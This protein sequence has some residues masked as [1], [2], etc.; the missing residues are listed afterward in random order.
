M[1]LTPEQIAAI[2]ARIEP[3]Y[4]SVQSALDQ[5]EA[6]RAAADAKRAAAKKLADDEHAAIMS[7]VEREVAPTIQGLIDAAGGCRG[8]FTFAH[9]PAH[10]NGT[11]ETHRVEFRRNRGA[12]GQTG[13]HFIV[14]PESPPPERPDF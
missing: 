2:K 6:V 14:H 9:G 11:R 5:V 4:P 3:L 1:A 10:E 12:K 8:W 13:D 7:A